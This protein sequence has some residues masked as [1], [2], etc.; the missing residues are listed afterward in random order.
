M[1][2]I[3]VLPVNLEEERM[4]RRALDRRW[5]LQL[6][7]TRHLAHLALQA[8]DFDRRGDGRSLNILGLLTEAS[9]ERESPQVLYFARRIAPGDRQRIDDRVSR[10]RA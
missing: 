1:P 4:L 5:I 3:T 6:E 2:I 9:P 7:G 8:E 10:L